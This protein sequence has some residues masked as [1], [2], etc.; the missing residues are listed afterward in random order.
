LCPICKEISVM[1]VRY[2]EYIICYMLPMRTRSARVH[3]TLA[4]PSALNETLGEG[5]SVKM[6]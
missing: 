1:N 6:R 4:I 2:Y 5:R 3:I